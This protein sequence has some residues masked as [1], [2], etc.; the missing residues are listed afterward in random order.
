[1]RYHKKY[2][3]FILGSY[4]QFNMVDDGLLGVMKTSWLGKMAK[5]YTHPSVVLW[6]AIE[7]RQLD[8]IF[9][10]MKN[11]PHPILDLGC[12]EGEIARALFGKGVIDVGLDNEAEMVKK[13]KKSQVYKKVILGDAQNLSFKKESFNLVFSNCVVEHIPDINKVLKEAARVLKKNGLFVFTVPSDKFGDYL[14]FS[15]FF[16][17]I[18]IPFLAKLYAIFRNRQLK[19]FHCYSQKFWQQ[20]LRKNNF[21]LIESKNYINP[22]TLSFWDWL[23]FKKKFFPFIKIPM[24]KMISYYEKDGQSQQGGAFLL[25]AKKMGQ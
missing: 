4:D 18:K 7:L 17:K 13:A 12:G 22:L 5:V 9:S 25:I 24:E 23:A 2:K 15:Q 10:K 19:H 3:F 16:K 1:M 6:R 21:I 20:K 11:I 8:R 14:F